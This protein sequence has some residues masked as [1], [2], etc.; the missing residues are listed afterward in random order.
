MTKEQ[1]QVSSK[2]VPYKIRF[3]KNV[4]QFKSL[5]NDVPRYIHQN[6]TRVRSESTR[7][8]VPSVRR[9]HVRNDILH[10]KPTTNYLDEI[11]LVS[12]MDLNRRQ[13]NRVDMAS[14]ISLNGHY[15]NFP[16]GSPRTPRNR[17]SGTRHFDKTND[18]KKYYRTTPQPAIE[19]SEVK[20]ALRI[21][22]APNLQKDT[23]ETL[24]SESKREKED[25][26][27]NIMTMTASQTWKNV[28][29]RSLKV[30]Q[31]K[32]AVE[33]DTKKLKPDKPV[34]SE[35]RMDTEFDENIQ[36]KEMSEKAEKARAMKEA[37]QKMMS[38]FTQWR[39]KV[40]STAFVKELDDKKNDIKT[41]R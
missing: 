36:T 35:R 24:T 23:A 17:Y 41:D 30:N 28:T 3:M 9:N 6:N 13:V 16:D 10:F 21:V 34:D 39:H 37:V 32:K 29:T 7:A 18:I 38:A 11:A 1:S 8:N 26:L 2:D 40:V 12:N 27:Q 33:D 20:S 19:I 31:T 25:V 14:R 5:N 22:P 4:E 15:N